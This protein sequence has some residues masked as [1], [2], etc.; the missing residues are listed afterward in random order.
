MNLRL[1]SYA[2]VIFAVFLGSALG[3]DT[4]V[5]MGDFS[6]DNNGWE[7]SLGAEFPGAKGTLQR[8]QDGI[9][10]MKLSADFSGGGNY[11]A[12]SKNLKTPLDIE[13]LIITLKGT[14]PAF[15]L[16]LSDSTGQTFQQSFPIDSASQEW[17]KFSIREFGN[18]AR[19]DIL[20]FGG[21]N[22]GI[23]RGP[24]KHIAIILHSLNVRPTRDTILIRG[25]EAKTGDAAVPADSG[26]KT[27]VLADFSQEEKDWTLSLGSEFPG[28]KGERRIEE[29]ADGSVKKGLRL[30]ADFSGGGRYVALG[31]AFAQPLSVDELSFKVRGSLSEFGLRVSDGQ[32][33]T[34]QQN[35]KLDPANN[36]WQTIVIK[37]FGNPQRKDIF[38]WGG[39]NDGV[40]RNPMKSAWIMINAPGKADANILYI[41][42]I[43]A[44]SKAFS[45]ALEPMG[46]P[47]E[48]YLTPD[49]PAKISW[50]AKGPVSPSEL[51]YE[52]VGYEGEF[53]SKGMAVLNEA[54]GQLSIEVKLSQ[55]YYEIIFKKLAYQSFGLV[56]LP[57]H[58]TARDAF[59]G[60]DGA[61][62][63]FPV[64]GKKELRTSYFA[65]LARC[66]IGMQRERIG[67]SVDA[68][69][70]GDV[71]CEG[72]G[73][74]IRDD[75]ASQG[76][77]IL[78]CFCAFGDEKRK[79]NPY[80]TTV[81]GMPKNWENIKL[82]FGRAWGGTEVWNE[83]DL[84][85]GGMI[86]GDRYVALLRSACY[87]ADASGAGNP[88]GGGVFNHVKK[89]AFDTY[90]IN[91]LLDN[92]DFFAYH[93]YYPPERAEGLIWQYRE[94]CK[95]Y[96]RPSI[97]FWMTEAGSG[98]TVGP[99]R[100]PR[101]EAAMSAS[102]IVAKAIECRACGNARH[103]AFLLIYFD[104]NK[105]NWGMHGKE[106]TPLRSMAAYAAAVR[107]LSRSKYI[108]DL[109]T[110]DPQI[111]RAR[112][113]AAPKGDGAVVVVYTGK[114]ATKT[115]VELGVLPLKIQGIDGRSLSMGTDGKV[116]VPDG[117]SFIFVKISDI[118]SILDRNTKAA[119]LSL[120]AA[121]NPGRRMTS[122]PLVLL[123]DTDISQVTYSPLGYA[124]KDDAS[125][126]MSAKLCN[127]SVSEKSFVLKAELPDGAQMLGG[128]EIVKGSLS[129]GSEQVL[130]WKL[131]LSKALGGRG[132]FV[133]VCVK[134]P[135][136]PNF[137]W[138]MR[139]INSE[140]ITARKLKEGDDSVSPE[141]MPKGDVWRAIGADDYVPIEY[142]VLYDG[143]TKAWARC[144]WQPGQLNVDVLVEDENFT[145]NFDGE[146]MWKGDSVQL[147]FQTPFDKDG[148]PSAGFTELSVALTKKG[149]QLYRHHAQGSKK[150][151]L[152]DASTFVKIVQ[153]GN[154]TLYTLRLPV[155]QFDLPELKAG[156]KLR[157]SLLINCNDGRARVGYLRWGDGIAGT[158]APAEYCKV[159]LIE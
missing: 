101:N 121:Q 5:Q 32:G 55:G 151:G 137:K 125:C 16:R 37:E 112:V 31:R 83:P 54:A 127:L 98:W 103:F 129:A 35:V 141:M 109:K 113:F 85:A 153:K 152:L 64:G 118:E 131:D 89:P 115:S 19:K 128:K 40:W 150:A 91:G 84:F 62:G 66:G 105:I 39:A 2:V 130:S 148:R 69:E 94:W 49:L 26:L 18:P 6:K 102:E 143:K 144:T 41:S 60:V 57:K 15:W 122:S 12:M 17:Q 123:P 24:A 30:S 120:I 147:A 74:G 76:I 146:T 88:M 119:E 45:A 106:N 90:A 23:W 58:E 36:G 82:G 65:M 140:K 135:D 8:E 156:M 139:F 155:E 34:F 154:R 126:T 9:G 3:A 14:A 138:V 114:P 116:P 13:E 100:P 71:K 86:P 87:L 110:R 149:P 25:I 56:V 4:L 80:P 68:A 97:P 78:E 142:V 33:Q 22:D 53:V 77:S 145:Q 134:S 48:F 44:K 124:P 50:E 79:P 72:E 7:F 51:A 96:G 28:A 10:Y 117:L 92:S 63:Y 42:K 27:V 75:A 20:H 157:F 70:K 1:L 81:K 67:F 61:F 38:H 46:A 104:E 111:K 108:G 93:D 132:K 11:I 107:N 133:D 47:L 59:W 73:K 21:A 43:E 136:D 52:I 159:E 95:E 158:K 99:P 29:F